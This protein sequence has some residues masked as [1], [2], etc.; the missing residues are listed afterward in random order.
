MHPTGSTPALPLAPIPPPL[1]QLQ[2]QPAPQAIRTTALASAQRV[3]LASAPAILIALTV[4]IGK[5]HHYTSRSITLTIST[6]I[7]PMTQCTT[8]AKPPAAAAA[9]LAASTS[10]EQ[11]ASTAAPTPATTPRKATSAAPTA[12][13]AKAATPAPPKSA[14]AVPLAQHPPAVLGVDPDCRRTTLLIRTA[15]PHTPTRH[16][17]HRRRISSRKRLRRRVRRVRLTPASRSSAGLPV[18]QIGVGS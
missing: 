5:F 14:T 7:T 10:T 13:T 11:E 17:C 4:T 15:T 18:P 6:A 16:M 12:T 2:H 9:P 1:P 8:P 3:C